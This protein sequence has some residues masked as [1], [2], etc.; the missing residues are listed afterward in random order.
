MTEIAVFGGTFDPPTKAHEGII[1]A[2][3]ERRDIDEVW[4]MPSGQR[5]DKADMLHD[6]A[7]LAML[8]LV[9]TE[10]F[11][12]TERLVV[13]DFEQ[14][15]PQPTQTHHTV[16]ALR[17]RYPEHRFW[18]VF[19]ADSYQAM[20][21][22]EH[23]SELQRTLPMLVVPRPGYALPEESE[24]VK[25]LIL[26]G[27]VDGSLSSSRLRE[28]RQAGVAIAN[29][30]CGAVAAYIERHKLYLPNELCDKVEK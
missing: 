11:E 23:G 6:A 2:C 13:T 9:K 25:Q 7:R 1:A 26:P 27:H 16:T 8:E 10:V 30:A 14:H 29:F 20:P 3:L 21:E 17:R 15:L 19:G 12:C 24:T 4:L 5:P 22:W 28:A 18:Y